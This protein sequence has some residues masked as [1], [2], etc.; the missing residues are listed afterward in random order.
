MEARPSWVPSSW[1]SK[2]EPV[3]R[4]TRAGGPRYSARRGG[5]DAEI[6]G[7]HAQ[8]ARLGLTSWV[9]NRPFMTSAPTQQDEREAREVRF[10]EP[11]K[12]R[13]PF[14]L[15]CGQRASA[16]RLWA[17]CGR[18]RIS[19]DRVCRRKLLLACQLA[20]FGILHAVTSLGDFVARCCAP[21]TPEYSKARMKRTPDVW[22]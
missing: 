10:A 6:E 3:A 15:R 4:P 19:P 11:A 20:I 8:L 2:R 21:S 12:Q 18:P 1:G 5:A 14:V 7:H 16:T 9:R 17:E 13:S 22:T